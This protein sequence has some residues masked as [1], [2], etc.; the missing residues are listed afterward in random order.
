MIGGPVLV[1]L[2]LIGI[3]CCCCA[4]CRAC[5]CPS[6]SPSGGGR[7]IVQ[8]IQPAVLATSVKSSVPMR[9]LVEEAWRIGHF[10]LFLLYVTLYNRTSFHK[11]DRTV[12]LRYLSRTRWRR[13]TVASIPKNGIWIMLTSVIKKRRE[14]LFWLHLHFGACC[15]SFFLSFFLFLIHS[16][17]YFAF[18][19]APWRL[20]VTDEVSFY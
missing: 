9:P 5:C 6:N 14:P 15:F 1:L 13:L 11:Y 8:P 3:C 18:I 10:F 7:V 2:I 19:V 4:C 20:F 17:F 16:I 12:K